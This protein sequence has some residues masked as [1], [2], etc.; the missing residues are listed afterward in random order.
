[1]NIG[2]TEEVEGGVLVLERGRLIEKGARITS[3]SREGKEGRP[4][5]KFDVTKVGMS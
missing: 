1:M 2:V 4:T 5:A 3:A